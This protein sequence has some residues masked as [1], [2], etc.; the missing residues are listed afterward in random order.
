MALVTITEASKLTGKARKTLYAHFKQGKLSYRMQVDGTKQVDTS[1]LIRVYG[2]LKLEVTQVTPPHVTEV[3][4]SNV[5]SD[6]IA[7]LVAAVEIMRQQQ[8]LDR[9]ENVLLRKQLLDLTD[10]VKSLTNRLEYKPES[11]VGQEQKEKSSDQVLSPRSLDKA[12]VQSAEVGE[13]I[14]LA[15]TP[16]A[17]GYMDIPCFLSRD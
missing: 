7:A 16:K 14:R 11:P 3:T 4:P 5:T 15:T 1:E 13:P 8:E 12:I 6:G 9:K 2:E 10:T 17:S